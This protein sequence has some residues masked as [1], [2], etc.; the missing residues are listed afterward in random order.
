MKEEMAREPVAGGRRKDET[1]FHGGGGGGGGGGCA[2][3]AGGGVASRGGVSR[4]GRLLRVRRARRTGA[5]IR[6]VTGR[7]HD[8]AAL[9]VDSCNSIQPPVS[10]GR[11]VAC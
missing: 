10:R 7:S 1:C 5:T 6:P 8:R 9:R 2:G 3:S 4:Q 11:F